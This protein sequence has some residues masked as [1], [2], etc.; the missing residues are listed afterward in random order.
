LHL[1]LI[2]IAPVSPRGENR[3]GVVIAA[4]QRLKVLRWCCI[5][6]QGE[7]LNG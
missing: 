3:A 5:R 7:N 1:A 6:I 4:T 2:G